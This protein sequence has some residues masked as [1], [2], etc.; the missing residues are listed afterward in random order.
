MST[1]VNET[2]TAAA[3]GASATERFHADKTPY[4]KLMDD[5]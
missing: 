4:A 3:S 2:A 5:P 1:T